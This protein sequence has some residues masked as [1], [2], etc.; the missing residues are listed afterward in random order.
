MSFYTNTYGVANSP[1]QSPPPFITDNRSPN[2][3]DINYPIF[4][5][6]LNS[7][8]LNLYFLAQKTS[9]LGYIQADWVLIGT[10][11]GGVQSLTG[12]SGGAVMP[13]TGAGNT[14]NVVGD[15][16]TITIAGNPATHT[17]TVSALGFNTTT[18]QEDSGTATPSAD[19]LNIFGANGIA[20]TGSGHTVTIGTDGTLATTYNED[21][22]SATPAGGILAIVGG[23]G[24]STSGAGNTVTINAMAAVPLMFTEDSGTATASANNINILGGAGIV[25]SGSGSTVRITATASGFAWNNVTATSANMVKENGYQA[26]N[27]GLVT[28]TLPTTGSS[29]FGD[30]IAIQGFGAG[31]WTIAQNSGQQIIF[32]NK[33]TTLG[34]GGSLSSTNQNDALEI[35]CS[36]TTSVWFVTRSIGNITVV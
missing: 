3:F 33:T 12:N 6:W 17:L 8:S 2:N 11:L 18:Y 1:S 31:G 22:G 24:V 16:T 14:I 15:G 10:N 19:T 25:T 32:G 26:N 35:V 30:T 36:S 20:T 9:N 7:S 29:T 4:S 5:F 13:D 34:A 28:L 23:T 27:V 21:S